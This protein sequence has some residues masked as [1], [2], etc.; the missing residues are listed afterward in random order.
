MMVSI[1]LDTP[2]DELASLRRE[3]AHVSEQCSITHTMAVNWKQRALA[4][5]KQ[6]EQLQQK[7]DRRDRGVAR[8]GTEPMLPKETL[9]KY[10]EFVLSMG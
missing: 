8:E 1:D 5:E 4:A 3:L 2:C 7:L 9:G 10:E 6:C